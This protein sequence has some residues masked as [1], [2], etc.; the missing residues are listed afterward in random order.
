MRSLVLL[1]AAWLGWTVLAR[2]RD[3]RA[4]RSSTEG[5]SELAPLSPFPDG[6]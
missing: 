6:A 4:G 5:P 1:L 2:T 3:A